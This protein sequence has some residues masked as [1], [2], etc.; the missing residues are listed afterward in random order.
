MAVIQH[1]TAV[2]FCLHVNLICLC[3]FYRWLVYLLRE[4]PDSYLS[5][6][7]CK[8]ANK[9]I[10]KNVSDP[11]KQAEDAARM[12]SAKEAC[13][14]L[15]EATAVVKE[16]GINK[17]DLKGL[18]GLRENRGPPGHPLNHM[19]QVHIHTCTHTH[20]HTNVKYPIILFKCIVTN[21]WPSYSLRFNP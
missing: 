4:E 1:S 14:C 2:M 9:R 10:L 20:T 17:A 6:C 8:P 7:L 3:F 19:G 18:E 5:V 21:C 12:L 15:H 16:S 13:M 11:L